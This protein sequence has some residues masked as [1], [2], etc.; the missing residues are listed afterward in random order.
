MFQVISCISNAFLRVRAVERARDLAEAAAARMGSE[1]SVSE[2]SSSRWG[3]R[4][5]KTGVILENGSL[6][7]V[8]LAPPKSI[9]TSGAKTGFWG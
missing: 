8:R 9:A 1:N 2:S 6:R 5:L 4:R 7:G 3:Q